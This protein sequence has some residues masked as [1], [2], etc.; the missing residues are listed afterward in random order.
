LS[1]PAAIE[2]IVEYRTFF[3]VE[4]AVIHSATG[5]LGCRESWLTFPDGKLVRVPEPHAYPTFDDVC[6]AI[7]AIW[8]KRRIAAGIDRPTAPA[9]TPRDVFEQARED[10]NTEIVT[11]ECGQTSA[12]HGGVCYRQYGHDGP[13]VGRIKTDDGKSFD[14]VW[15]SGPRSPLV[16]A[17]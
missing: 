12:A 11:V 5:P 15:N 14:N 6:A 9:P 8:R 4:V 1:Q 3:D 16:L 7:V 17:S 2:P 10:A 13:H